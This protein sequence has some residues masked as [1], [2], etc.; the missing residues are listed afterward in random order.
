M[1]GGLQLRSFAGLLAVLGFFA[2]APEAAAD[3][4]VTLNTS[5]TINQAKFFLGD[6]RPTGA[7]IAQSFVR[8]GGTTNQV[9]GYNTDARPLEFQEYSSPSLTHSLHLSS[10]PVVTLNGVQYRE[11]GLQVYQTP[12]ASQY[13]TLDKL[14]VFLGSASNLLGLANLGPKVYDLDKGSSNGS[15]FVLFDHTAS[16]GAGD[17][18]VY[19]PNSLFAG[20]NQYVYLF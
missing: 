7:G 12:K 8:M 13:I 14:Q 4:L 19:V 3:Y 1:R 16:S 6:P 2:L 11:F 17:L 9:Q 18:F 20:A 15:N 5:T 10:V